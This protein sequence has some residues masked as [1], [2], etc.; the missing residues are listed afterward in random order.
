VSRLLAVAG[1]SARMLAEA[2]R[3]GGYR[4]VAL[5]LFGDV[6]TRRAAEA[7]W[8]IGAP[9][10]LAIDGEVLLA[11]LRELR[12]AGAAGWIAGS[13]FEGE[14][15]LL[16]AAARVLPLI[17]NSAEV[18]AAVR[19]P[20][21]FFG[22]LIALGIPHPETRLVPPST[23]AGW[24]RKNA[25]S[26]GG[27]EVRPAEGKA[28]AGPDGAGIHYQRL[29]PGEPMSALFLADGRRGRVLGV[30]R[31]IVRRLGGRPF[32]FRGCIG[33][34]PVTP[35]LGGALQ[36]IVDALTASYGLR[37]LNGLDFLLDADRLAVLELNPRP[38]AS[39]A[40][41]PD[42]L[43]GGLMRAHLAASLAGRLPAGDASGPPVAGRAPPA[44]PVRGFEVVF[45]RT[46]HR[47]DAAA[48]DALA[49]HPWCHDLPVAGSRLVRGDPLCTVSAVGGTAAEVQALL[50]R[51]RRQIP[52][53]LE[54][55]HE[56][57][58]NSPPR[59]SLPRARELERQ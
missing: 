37:G 2:A 21:G 17:G 33:P 50:V 38:P 43:A 42:A 13:G 47:V 39:M 19:D 35:A 27:R 12:A 49:R 25:A 9:A 46:P 59:R 44:R 14:P 29:A 48:A 53:L 34:L 1:L 4:P 52:S 11:A 51:R 40:L 58:G 45:A 10:R 8:P 15:A 26:S 16:A 54:Q 3:D 36:G 30:N 31:Q 32:I 18:A 23:P 24:L 5:D 7:W 22:R 20:A 28:P 57:S 56:S 55:H 41:Y 6:D